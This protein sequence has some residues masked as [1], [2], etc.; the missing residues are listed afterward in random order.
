[1]E[2][3]NYPNLAAALETIAAADPPAD[4]LRSDLERVAELLGE[5]SHE[6]M[7]PALVFRGRDGVVVSIPIGN[8]LSCG[9]APGCQLRFAELREISRHHFTISREEDVYWLLDHGSFN[10]TRIRGQRISKHEL[11]DGDLINASGIIFL[12]VKE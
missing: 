1:M 10:G 5:A 4:K 12:F 9:R 8:R 7:P 11:R 2:R 6:L 3:E